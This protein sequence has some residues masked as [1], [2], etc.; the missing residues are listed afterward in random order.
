MC[1]PTCYGPLL[2]IDAVVAQSTGQTFPRILAECNAKMVQI[3]AH[4]LTGRGSRLPHLLGEQ[5]YD[6]I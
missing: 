5:I 3:A 6:R 4:P 2:N 1:T